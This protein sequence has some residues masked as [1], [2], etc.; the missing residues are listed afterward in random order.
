[1]IDI[2]MFCNVVIIIFQPQFDEW[3]VHHVIGYDF[4]ADSVNEFG[5]RLVTLMQS[6]FLSNSLSVLHGAFIDSCVHHCMFCSEHS[7]NPWIGSHI[8]STFH[9]KYI[10]PATAFHEW[11]S[12]SL[13]GDRER[14][15]YSITNQLER[16][17]FFQNFS[18]PCNTCCLCKI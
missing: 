14:D 2:E 1:M 6:R 8:H 4:S 13:F 7:E 9:S 18:F 15:L 16:R 11:F 5:S 12:F 3:Q 10:N 17:F